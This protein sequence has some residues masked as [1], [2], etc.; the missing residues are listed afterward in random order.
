MK[1]RIIVLIMFLVVNF[2][3]TLT[4]IAIFR[5]DIPY[6]AFASI[7]AHLIIL[8]KTNYNYLFNIKTN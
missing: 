6:L 3:L 1:N 2:L 4:H 7:L 8:I 5:T